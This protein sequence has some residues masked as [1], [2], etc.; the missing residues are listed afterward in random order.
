MLIS[1]AKVTLVHVGY[2]GVCDSVL[3]NGELWLNQYV[4]NLT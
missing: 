2:I 3:D 1:E 4:Y